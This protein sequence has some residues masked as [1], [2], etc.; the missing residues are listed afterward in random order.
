VTVKN[1]QNSP[2][3]IAER[4]QVID[5]DSHV[6][7]PPNLWTA[8]L[9]ARFQA[10]APRIVK[11]EATGQERW[12]IGGHF[13]IGAATYALAEWKDYW[14]AGPTRF[15]DA[16]PGAWNPRA[17]LQ[18]MDKVGVQAQVLYPNILG[19]HI[20]NFLEYDEPMRLA[21]VQ[22]FNDFQTEFCEEDPNRLLPLAF[23]PWWDL[24]ASIA[25]LDRC[26]AMGHKGVN[27]GWRFENLGF[28]RL[29]DDHWAPLLARMQETGMSCN[30]HIGFGSMK[31]EEIRSA[32]EIMAES[33]DMA[34]ETSLFMLGNATCIAELIFGRIAH[35]YPNLKFVSVESGYGFLPY[36][37]EAFDWQFSNSGARFE[38]RDM[39]LPSEYFRRQIYS[40]F[41]F[42]RHS[43]TRLIDLYPDNVMFE[44][45]YPHATSLSPGENTSAKSARETIQENLG[46]LSEETLTKVLNRTA[47]RV[48]NLG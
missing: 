11:D 43:L 6:L 4:I 1:L 3:R 36:L 48:Y 27:F 9:P 24:N 15:E 2:L 37:L 13:A 8:R 46:M 47:A 38:H 18:W 10:D 39:L 35:R 32:Q 29:R 21:C 5:V 19:F 33:L 17:R 12:L 14:P 44:T 23:L 20:A 30:F 40:S 7:E 26:I 41:W 34:K 42:E 45:D 22:A 31:E 28:P 16:T 25:E